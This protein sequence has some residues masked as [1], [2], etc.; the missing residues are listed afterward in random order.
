MPPSLSEVY[1]QSLST[2]YVEMQSCIFWKYYEFRN[3]DDIQPVYLGSLWCSKIKNPRQIRQK[4]STT[5][6]DRLSQWWLATGLREN[7]NLTQ[8]VKLSNNQPS[9]NVISWYSDLNRT[10]FLQIEMIEPPIHYTICTEV[11]NM[12][13]TYSK[14]QNKPQTEIVWAVL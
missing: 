3:Q 4:F 1:F 10:G 12:V 6:W 5:G 13:H 11:Q 9:K 7:Y 8:S 14:E 2:L